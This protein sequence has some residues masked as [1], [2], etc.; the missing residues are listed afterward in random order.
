MDA[1]PVG[2]LFDPGSGMEKIRIQDKHLGSTTLKKNLE[3]MMEEKTYLCIK[4]RTL[5][6]YVF[7][8]RSVTEMFLTLA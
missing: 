3:N 4:K 1:N 8:C 7:L 2:N 6:L 5:V